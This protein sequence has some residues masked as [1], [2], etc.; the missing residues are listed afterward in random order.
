MLAALFISGLY[1]IDGEYKKY[2]M[3][4]CFADYVFVAIKR[5]LNVI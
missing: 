4:N 5:N 1:M 3:Q 2:S